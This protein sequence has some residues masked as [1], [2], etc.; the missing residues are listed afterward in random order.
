MNRNVLLN[1]IF[2]VLFASICF[3]TQSVAQ[4]CPSVTVTNPVDIGPYD[5]GIAAP[6]DANGSVNFKCTPNVYQISASAGLHSGGSL[7]GRRASNGSN[8]I[9]YNLYTNAGRT[10]IWG[11]GTGTTAQM[12]AQTTNNASGTPVPFFARVPAGQNAD[13]NTFYTDTI[14]VT[15]YSGT[16]VVA[17]L[18]INIRIEVV[19]RCYV[20][21]TDLV[22]GNYDPVMTNVT[23]PLDSASNIQVFCTAGT[24]AAVGL[25]QGASGNRRM[26]GPAGNML[27]YELYQDAARTVIW[28]TV[29]TRS[30]T[31]SDASNPLGGAAG[32]TVFGR[33]PGGQDAVV[34]PY[35]DSV[36]VVINY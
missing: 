22:F 31:S 9:A 33:V 12:I 10:T 6:Q 36:S 30:G 23:A 14:A 24:S 35:S 11:D 4:N 18:V 16:T 26:Q 1:V 27:Q 32:W 19:R 5:P 2:T 3:V 15:V 25:N 29:S 8:T 21:A 17:N 13:S 20:V 7:A 34:G 28:D